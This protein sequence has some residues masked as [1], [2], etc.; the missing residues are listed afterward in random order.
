VSERKAD[1]PRYWVTYLVKDLPVGETFKPTARHM[2]IIPWFVTDKN[3]EE[4]IKSFMEEFEGQRRFEITVGPHTEFKNRRKIAINIVPAASEL[5]DLH[6]KTLEWFSD[7]NARWAVKNPYVG[8]HYIPHIRRRV[9]HN[10]SEGESIEISSLS[11]VEASR[12]GDD[13][14][15]VIARVGFK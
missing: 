6:K 15:I 2:T 9:G 7:L 8:E 14:R 10:L 13:L 4:V 12:R 11:L 5:K 1:K 3:N